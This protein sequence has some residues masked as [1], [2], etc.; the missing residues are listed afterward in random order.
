M[1]NLSHFKEP[2]HAVVMQF[3]REHPFAFLAGSD[4]GHRPVVTQVP[5]FIDETDGK[6]YLSGHI[7]KNTDH[8]NAFLQNANVLAVFTGP[9]SFVSASWYE[10][11]QQVPGII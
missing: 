4:A 7:M 9:H 8:H 10:N 2:D 1:Y 5:V 6:L 3:V 11:K